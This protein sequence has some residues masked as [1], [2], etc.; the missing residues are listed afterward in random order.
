[1]MNTKKDIPD[2]IKIVIKEFVKK[3]EE[4][5]NPCVVYDTRKDAVVCNLRGLMTEDDAIKG[6]LAWLKRNAGKGK[7]KSRESQKK[8]GKK[9][10]ESKE[11]SRRKFNGVGRCRIERSY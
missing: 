2:H 8:D 11:K 5:N 1:M 10:R 6:C 9:S 4:C 7:K 3:N